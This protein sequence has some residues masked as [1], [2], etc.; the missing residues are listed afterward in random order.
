MAG[1]CA[2]II[3]ECDACSKPGQQKW[4]GLFFYINEKVRYVMTFIIIVIAIVQYTR[5]AF[6]AEKTREEITDENIAMIIHPAEFNIRNE[7]A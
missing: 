2:N 3:A 7:L 5:L 6:K 1:L 4:P